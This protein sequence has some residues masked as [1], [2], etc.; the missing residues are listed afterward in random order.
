[1]QIYINKVVF[2]LPLSISFAIYNMSET[3]SYKSPFDDVSDYDPDQENGY[4]YE[5]QYVNERGDRHSEESSGYYFAKKA[6]P[7]SSNKKYV[8]RINPDTK[9]RTRI[10]F[11]PTNATPNTIIKNAITG[12]HQGLDGHYV[13]VGTEDE[14]LF[15]SVILATGELGQ[16]SSILFYDTPEQY[17]R[18]FFTKL[19]QS[20]KEQWTEKK[21]RALFQLK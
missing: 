7:N 19:S 1:M 20:T 18:H 14:D 16:T 5:G 15:F 4:E 12:T 17:E 3:D 8:R 2:H 9:K 21:N 13:R 6:D 11:F 10:E